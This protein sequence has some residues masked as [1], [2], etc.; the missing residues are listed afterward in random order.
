M[1]IKKFG[2]R[3]TYGL[4]YVLQFRKLPYRT[5]WPP[6][7]QKRN[8]TSHGDPTVFIHEFFIAL[9]G[10]GKLYFTVTV[11]L[12][13]EQICRYGAA[14]STTWSSWLYVTTMEILLH[15]LLSVRRL[16]KQPSTL[17]AF[18]LL[19]SILLIKLVQSLQTITQQFILCIPIIIYILCYTSLSIIYLISCRPV[20]FLFIYKRI[21]T[22]N[23]KSE[24][25]NPLG[26][27]K[28]GSSITC[29][30]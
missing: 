2:Y 29:G 15:F 16:F 3:C 24:G 23:L 30:G 11:L 28:R 14:F 5:F 8:C 26:R 19:K 25:K 22:S 27:Y 21:R 13:G 4:L 10:I 6:R 20:L 17:V 9:D 1:H 18:R 12:L 7:E